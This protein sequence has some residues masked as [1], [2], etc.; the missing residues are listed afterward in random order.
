[1]TAVYLCRDIR[2]GVIY[3]WYPAMDL[4]KY[5]LHS[6]DIRNGKVYCGSVGMGISSYQIDSI[7]KAYNKQSNARLRLDFKSAPSQG[8]YADVVTLSGNEGLTVDT[9]DKIS[10]NLVDIL[11]KDKK[12]AS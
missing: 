8:I 10:Y 9:Y 12:S 1:M 4:L 7:I 6:A 11:L 5:Y 2:Y 3:V